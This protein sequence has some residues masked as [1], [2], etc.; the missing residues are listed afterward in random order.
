M[1][2]AIKS[3][4]QEAT[5]SAAVILL[6]FLTF[7]YG[8]F[9]GTIATWK[10]NKNNGG[11]GDPERIPDQCQKHAELDATLKQS[12]INQ[13]RILN[14]L[15]GGNSEDPGIKGIVFGMSLKL[16]ENTEQHKEIFKRIRELERP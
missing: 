6:A 7:I 8:M 15:D 5:P 13:T 12:S 1:G 4:M 14:L 9:Q 2:I 3:L 16:N 11:E 10:W